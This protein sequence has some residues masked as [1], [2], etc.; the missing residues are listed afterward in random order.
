VDVDIHLGH[1]IESY[2]DLSSYQPRYASP[3][4]D[5]SGKPMVLINVQTDDGP[6]LWVYGDGQRFLVE[7][8]G[9]TIWA[10]WPATCTIDDA[11]LNLLGPIL[12]FVLRLRG[13]TCLHASAVAIDGRA[14]ALVGRPSAGKSTTAAAFVGM[15]YP[16]VS[17]DVV[18]LVD[19]GSPFL[20]VPGYPSI[21]L[22]PRAVTTLYGPDATLPLLTPTRDKRRLDLGER[23]YPFQQHPLPLAAIYYLGSRRTDERAPLVEPASHHVALMTLVADTYTNYVLTKDMRAREFDVLG[24]LT[25]TVPFRF[26]T[27]HSDAARLPQLCRAILDDLARQ[28]AVA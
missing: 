21:R 7:P 27:P 8:G 14:V 15:G 5:R 4:L 3:W 19:G 13:I 20:V 17:E 23:G 1:P 12:G 24:Q 16:L 9:R 25:R 28:N 26:V 2:V 18:P 22:W 11:A 10:D 6:R